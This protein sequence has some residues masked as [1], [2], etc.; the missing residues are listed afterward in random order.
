[1]TD[2]DKNEL[3][4]YYNVFV[5]IPFIDEDTKNKYR[6]E[7]IEIWKQRYPDEDVD[8]NLP[9][10]VKTEFKTNHESYIDR[11]TKEQEWIDGIKKNYLKM[12]NEFIVE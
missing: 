7:L 2:T 9:K 5:S 6:Q 1:M 12:F 11:K 10:I 3:I 4:M 8:E